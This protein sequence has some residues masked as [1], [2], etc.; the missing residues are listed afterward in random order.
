[1]NMISVW[2]AWAIG[3]FIPL[4]AFICWVGYSHQLRLFDFAFTFP[5][6]LLGNFGKF[7]RIKKT[8][9]LD[10]NR[11]DQSCHMF[12]K[13]EE[14]C[15]AY[16]NCL[17][18]GSI[19]EKDKFNEM[20][21]YLRATGQSNITP[22]NW[23]MWVILFILTAGEAAGTGALISEFVATNVTSN[24]T[25]FFTWGTAVILATVLLGLTHMSG[26]S[27]FVKNHIKAMIGDTNENAT[28]HKWD[29]TLSQFDDVDQ[30][31]EKRFMVRMDR[32]KDRGTY[33]W[34][35]AVVIALILVFTGVFGARW[36]GIKK[37]NTL[38][39][40]QMEKNGATGQAINPFAAMQN[41]ASNLPPSVKRAQT[42][43]RKKV[44]KA[45]GK[46]MLGQGFFATL[47]LSLLY[48]IVQG[49]GFSWSYTHNFFNK[50]ARK[51]YKEMLGK[52]SYDSYKRYVIKPVALTAD[53]R[54]S[55]LREFMIGTTEGSKNRTILNNPPNFH[56]YLLCKAEEE[57]N[58]DEL[59]ATHKA[60]N[61]TVSSRP[62]TESLSSQQNGN[63]ESS[64]ERA[65]KPDELAHQFMQLSS[66][67]E[68]QNFLSEVKKNCG[69]ETKQAFHN[70]VRC[71][72]ED[73]ARLG[74]LSDLLDD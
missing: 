48:L 61:T 20:Q 27:L 25:I 66:K 31:S 56:D 69:E 40:V 39:I 30:P 67:D 58:A 14:L 41:P 49:L 51:F 65:G 46:E 59:S 11:D 5:I 45:I 22:M 73:K 34:T 15:D 54:L 7:K 63:Q 1:M 3:A 52:P 70:A 71:L 17:P 60:K 16:I 8:S 12:S 24:E 32:K 68:K 42:Q 26:S 4:F 35:V 43:T 21:E 29:P 62:D 2:W 57:E 33:G 47:L 18:G 10:G 19:L 36:Y 28:T 64:L 6:R 72:K 13:E 50:T 74:D 53:A 38:Q 55:E 9:G 37:Q 23:W 44:A